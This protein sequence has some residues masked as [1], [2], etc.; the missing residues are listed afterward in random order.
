[1]SEAAPPSIA[2]ESQKASSANEAAPVA[3]LSA[4]PDAHSDGAARPSAGV[5]ASAPLLHTKS[6][7][8]NRLMTLLAVLAVILGALVY[9]GDIDGRVWKSGTIAAGASVGMSSNELSSPESF[10]EWDGHPHQQQ[11]QQHDDD[12]SN[13]DEYDDS[14]NGS[15][16]TESIDG[17]GDGYDYNDTISNQPNN[18]GHDDTDDIHET[19]TKATRTPR[20]RGVVRR[21]SKRAVL[22]RSLPPRRPSA[23][24][25]ASGTAPPLHNGPYSFPVRREVGSQ[26]VKDMLWYHSIRIGAAALPEENEGHLDASEAVQPE[27]P[28]QLADTQLLALIGIQCSAS[29]VSKRVRVRR[30]W[31]Q[32]LQPDMFIVFVIAARG[33]DRAAKAELATEHQLHGDILLLDAVDEGISSKSFRQLATCSALFGARFRFYIKADLDSY[34][35]PRQYG[36]MLRSLPARPHTWGGVAFELRKYTRI[37]RRFPYMSG[38]G[39][40]VSADL[41]A[42]IRSLCSHP[43]ATDDVCLAG[44]GVRP[45]DVAMGYAIGSLRQRQPLDGGP[46]IKPYIVR[47]NQFQ[48]ITLGQRQWSKGG[49]RLL[50]CL[51][52]RLSHQ[53]PSSSR[54]TC[55]VPPM[56]LLHGVKQ[57][58]DWEAVTAYYRDT[59]TLGPEDEGL[60]R[61]WRNPGYPM[62]GYLDNTPGW[63]SEADLTHRR[64]TDYAS[65]PPPYE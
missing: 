43:A 28:E 2:I 37:P 10:E 21:T 56:L 51:K 57:E 26:Y 62:P 25:S 8:R 32:W 59:F 53:G 4:A 55:I 33:L 35:L 20:P 44:D 14:Y 16:E 64:W 7:A 29:S 27:L 9:R 54:P 17:Q 31:A 39:Y 1:M 63:P 61:N 13:G 36:A 60:F 34:L 18:N 47:L 15:N 50:G 19:R 22:R 12:N 11:Q 6:S 45:E 40:F 24:P 46:S 48:P 38:S 41:A 30:T 65:I 49:A 3:V 58:A 42:R 52:A 23:S 5:S